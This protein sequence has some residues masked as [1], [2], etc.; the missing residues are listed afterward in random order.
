MGVH[1]GY[2]RDLSRGLGWLS[3]C[4]GAAEVL[5]PR[6]IAR[7][8]GLQGS[9]K[10]VSGYGLREIATGIGILSSANPKPWIWGRVAGDLLDMVSLTDG[11]RRT[12]PRRQTV[13]RALLAIAGIAAIDVLSARALGRRSARFDY[14]RRSGLP[15]PPAAMRGAAGDA[16]VPRDMRIPDA[17]RPYPG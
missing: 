8:L 4:L 13:G 15:R 7:T 3:I 5:G 2:A 1:L 9:E 6:P 10:V 16:E 12:N 11:L 17:L 14:S